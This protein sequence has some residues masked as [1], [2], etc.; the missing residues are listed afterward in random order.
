MEHR[1]LEG[2]RKGSK[3]VYIDENLYFRKVKRPNGNE[4]FICYQQI[5]DKQLKKDFI[6]SNQPGDET[7][8]MICDESR[9]K[10]YC[11]ARVVLKLDGTFSRNSIAHTKHGNHKNIVAD[12]NSLREMESLCNNMREKLPLSAHKLSPKEV[13][14]QVMAK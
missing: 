14:L 11:T 6:Q 3:L 2:F 4:E 9:N 13:F 7:V 12:L 1:I 10:T 5:L 8:A